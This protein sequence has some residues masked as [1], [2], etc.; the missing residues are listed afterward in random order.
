VFVVLIAG[1]LTAFLAAVLELLWNCR[2][3]AVQEK[4]PCIGRKSIQITLYLPNR[5]LFYAAW[6]TESRW[7]VSKH[8]CISFASSVLLKFQ[9]DKSTTICAKEPS[10]QRGRVQEVKQTGNDTETAVFCDVAP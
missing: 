8:Y 6:Q 2:K 7:P 3:I 1:T 4:V 9:P 5:G 10:G